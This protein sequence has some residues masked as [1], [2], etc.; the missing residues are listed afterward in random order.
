VS[1]TFGSGE[2]TY[3]IY[4][5]D[6]GDHT[7]RECSLDGRV[8]LT[9][10]IPDAAATFMS[11][12]PFRRCTHTALS[13]DAGAVAAS[14]GI[15]R[16][17]STQGGG[18]RRGRRFREVFRPIGRHARAIQRGGRDASQSRAGIGIGRG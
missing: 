17:P 5:T 11:G 13:P 10:G 9:I 6:D 7:V 15:H 16:R 1:A 8:L 18:R 2:F 4:L 14:V 3:V 12:N